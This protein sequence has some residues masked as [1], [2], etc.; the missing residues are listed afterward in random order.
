MIPRIGKDVEEPALSHIFDGNFKWCNPFEIS[1]V[2]HYRKKN[3]ENNTYHV[4]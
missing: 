4:I 1:I 2:W 3:S